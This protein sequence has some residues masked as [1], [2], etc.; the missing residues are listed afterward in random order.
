ML[1]HRTGNDLRRD[2]FLT[3]ILY[4]LRIMQAGGWGNDRVFKEVYRH[5]LP[6]EVEKMNKIAITYFESYDTK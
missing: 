5:T 2:T 3:G 1:Q 6:E 4:Y